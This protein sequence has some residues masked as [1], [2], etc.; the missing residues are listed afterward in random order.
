MTMDKTIAALL[1]VPLLGLAIPATLFFRKLPPANL[2]ASEKELAGFSSQPV[3]V[4]QP[5]RLAVYSGLE[6]PLRPPI[7][8][9]SAAKAADKNF[10]PG[11]IPLANAAAARQKA[12]PAEYRPGVSMIYSDGRAR[13]AIID[14][15]VLHEGASIGAGKVVKIEKTRVLLRTTG[16]DIWLNID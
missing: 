15:H 12:G 4:S 8:L 13:M 7:V 11:P 9:G 10:P 1:L 14:G 5:G 3:A 6:C 2:S 16:K